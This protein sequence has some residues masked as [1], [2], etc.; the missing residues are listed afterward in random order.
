MGP[1]ILDGPAV[2]TLLPPTTSAGHVVAAPLDVA[3]NTWKVTCVSMG[4]P[5]A[6]IYSNNTQET[7]EVWLKIMYISI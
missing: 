4:N 1:P 7:L 5:H 3:G 2:P 6:V